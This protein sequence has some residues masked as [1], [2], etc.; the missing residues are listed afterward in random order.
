[1]EI[2][3]FFR[4]DSVIFLM[5]QNRIKVIDQEC[6]LILFVRYPEPGKVKTRL[7]R[8]GN[9][10]FAANVYRCFVEDCLERMSQGR[11]RLVIAFDPPEKESAFLQLFGRNIRLM[12]QRGA[13]LGV[14][15]YQALTECF[16]GGAKFAIVIGSD[17]PDL[18]TTFIDEAFDALQSQDAVIGPAKDGGYYLIGF[19]RKSLCRSFFENMVWSTDSVFQETLRRLDLK[20]VS[21]HLLPTWQ[22]IDT[23]DDLDTLIR[24][25][26]PSDFGMSKTI[27]FLKTHGWAGSA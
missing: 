14:R 20:G 22:D 15:M 23:C 17:V 4:R 7:I 26:D 5:E 27:S 10:Y 6:C 21:V 24:E 18:P 3:K 8:K 16:A 9:G 25:Y 19:S 12:P 13:D 1:M 11:H 2:E